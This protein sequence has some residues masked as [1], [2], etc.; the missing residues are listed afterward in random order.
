MSVGCGHQH[1]DDADARHPLDEIDD[2]RFVAVIAHTGD[3]H[4]ALTRAWYR[5]RRGDRLIDIQI[6]GST[7]RRNRERGMAYVFAIECQRQRLG[8]GDQRGQQHRG[9]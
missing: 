6:D 3:N 7:L 4:H 9:P 1:G 8:G 5:R 2:L